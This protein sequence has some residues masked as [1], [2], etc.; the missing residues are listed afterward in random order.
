MYC[1]EC[2]CE[3]L[4]GVTTCADCGTELVEYLPEHLDGDSPPGEMPHLNDLLVF[5]RYPRAHEAEVARGLLEA[6]GIPAIT[7]W[8]DWGRIDLQRESRFRQHGIRLLIREEDKDAADLVF[9]EVGIREDDQ[10]RPF[11]EAS[12]RPEPSQSEAR[13]KILSKILLFMFILILL[14]ALIQY[15]Y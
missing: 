11:A 8:D 1:P 3:Y 9:K 13:E 15:F 7:T 14:F 6:N 5:R 4:E 12:E 2:K 10:Y